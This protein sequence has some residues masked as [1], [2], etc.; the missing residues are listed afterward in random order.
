MEINQTHFPN[1]IKIHSQIRI[2]LRNNFRV[3]INKLKHPQ[4]KKELRK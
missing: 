3:K 2:P 1:Q 4:N